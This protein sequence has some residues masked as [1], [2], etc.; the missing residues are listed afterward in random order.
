MTLVK[1][2]YEELNRADNKRAKMLALRRFLLDATDIPLEYGFI[3][4]L[5]KLYGEAVVF[6]AI[7]ATVSRNFGDNGKRLKGFLVGCCKNEVKRSTLEDAR[8]GG[9]KEFR[10]LGEDFRERVRYKKGLN[11]TN[12]DTKK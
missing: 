8:M 1:K 9:R 7:I 3:S 12:T 10:E 6:N 2:Y 4:K 11:G 5:L